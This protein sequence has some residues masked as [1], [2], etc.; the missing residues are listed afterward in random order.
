MTDETSSVFAPRMCLCWGRRRGTIAD[1]V[2]I[3]KEIGTVIGPMLRA[4]AV[5]VDV[6]TG[7]GIMMVGVNK[8][9][10][11]V[12]VDFGIAIPPST[13]TGVSI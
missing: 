7:I 2:A 4:K 12:A 6:V 9:A 1:P 5:E 11:A 10:E 13:I 3:D 8:P